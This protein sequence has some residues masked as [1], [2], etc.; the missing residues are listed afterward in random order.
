M[1]GSGC[2]HLLKNQKTKKEEEEEGAAGKGKMEE[3]A[4]P[5]QP[6]EMRAR[7]DTAPHYLGRS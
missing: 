1:A 3:K 4:E 2:T 6:S 5:S 7:R